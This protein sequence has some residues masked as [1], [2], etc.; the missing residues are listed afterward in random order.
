LCPCKVPFHF[1][2]IFISNPFPFHHIHSIISI[3]SYPFHHIRSMSIPFH[4]IKTSER[5]HGK[6]PHIPISKINNGVET[7]WHYNSLQTVPRKVLERGFLLWR[8]N[9]LQHLGA[10]D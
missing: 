9:V 3:P 4:F 7:D 8:W 5:I 6:L 2:F 10:T 1:H